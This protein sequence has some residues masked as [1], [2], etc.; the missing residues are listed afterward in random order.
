ME[1][2]IIDYKWLFTDYFAK[3]YRLYNGLWEGTKSII[4]PIPS[5]SVCVDG[6][7]TPE[8]RVSA[9]NTTSTADLCIKEALISSKLFL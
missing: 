6:G 5:L 9:E 3:N 4:I 8:Q 1:S 7:V 2:I